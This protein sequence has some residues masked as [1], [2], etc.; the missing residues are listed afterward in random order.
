[1]INKKVGLLKLA[2]MFEQSKSEGLYPVLQCGDGN[3]VRIYSQSQDCSQDD[4]VARHLDKWVEISGVSDNLRGHWRTKIDLNDVEAIIPV[5][6]SFENH[7][8]NEKM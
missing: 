8:D 4:I 2:L 1:M 3:F 5:S 6:R 7:D